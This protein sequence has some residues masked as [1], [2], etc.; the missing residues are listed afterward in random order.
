MR[1]EKEDAPILEGN[2][3]G[4]GAK[5]FH[6]LETAAEPELLMAD[7]TAAQLAAFATYQTKREVISLIL[8]EKTA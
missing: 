5:L 4:E 3:M 8:N 1:M 2:N 6:A 7:M